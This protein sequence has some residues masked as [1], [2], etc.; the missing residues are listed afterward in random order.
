M[1]FFKSLK[2]RF[3]KEGLMFKVLT[4]VSTTLLLGGLIG[5]FSHDLASTHIHSS[6]PTACAGAYLLD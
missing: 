2:E 3:Q 6:H 5:W 1:S 4:L